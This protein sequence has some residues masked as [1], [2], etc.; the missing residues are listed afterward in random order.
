MVKEENIS[1][2]PPSPLQSPASAPF[3]PLSRSHAFDVGILVL[4][5][6]LGDFLCVID[7]TVM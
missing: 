2:H 3:V 4:E 5:A 1:R 6:S 7:A